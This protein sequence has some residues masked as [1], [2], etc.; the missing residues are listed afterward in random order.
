MIS[1]NQIQGHSL[2]LALSV[3]A[4]FSARHFYPALPIQW[5]VVWAAMESLANFCGLSWAFGQS[6]TVFYS[7]FAG[8]ILFRLASIGVITALLCTCHVPI[9]VPL[10]TLVFLYF[11]LSLVQLPFLT[12]GLR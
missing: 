12:Y 1:R 6:D 4:F 9:M 10:L 5:I 11:S 3:A 8:G 7:M 2:I